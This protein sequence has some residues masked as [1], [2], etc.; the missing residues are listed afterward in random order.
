MSSETVIALSIFLITY[1]IIISEK[2]HRIILS[3]VG[4]LLLC[5]RISS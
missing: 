1:A 4:A 2:V 5:S 3:L